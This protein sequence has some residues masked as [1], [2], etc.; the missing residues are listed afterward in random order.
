LLIGTT[1]VSAET[2]RAALYRVGPGGGVD[3]VLDGLTESNGLGWSPDGRTMYFVDSVEPVVRRY[4]Y[5]PDGDAVRR[6]KDLVTLAGSGVGSPD[7]LVV[8][9]EG[10]VWVALW[11]GAELRRYSPSG[12]LMKAWPVPVSQP[13]CPALGSDGTVYLTTAWEGLPPEGR[14]AQPWAGHLL[15]RQLSCRPQNAH[16]F[17]DPHGSAATR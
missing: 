6:G 1:S 15:S 9:A 11:G 7:G 8:D 10:A 2:G 12:E 5:D 16:Y 3:V 17:V 13:T 14:A 4:E